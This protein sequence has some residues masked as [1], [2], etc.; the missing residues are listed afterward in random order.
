MEL[1]DGRRRPV[2]AGRGAVAVDVD[3]APVEAAREWNGGDVERVE[4]E[5]DWRAGGVGHGFGRAVG[6]FW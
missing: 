2:V 6:E 5:R 1:V 3:E 4:I